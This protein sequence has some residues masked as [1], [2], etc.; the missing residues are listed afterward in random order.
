[1]VLLSQ[2]IYGDIVEYLKLSENVEYLSYV[3]V[4]KWV[5]IFTNIGLS[6][7]LILTM[8]RKEEKTAKK[9]KSKEKMQIEEVVSVDTLSDRERSFLTRKL[10]SKAEILMDKRKKNVS[11]TT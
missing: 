9:S 8:F 5:L 2:W 4:G 11:N 1:M 3:L 6:A 10:R 7:Y